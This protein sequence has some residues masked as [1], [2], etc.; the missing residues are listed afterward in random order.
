[1]RI[2]ISVLLFLFLS[3]IST[4]AA[5]DPMAMQRRVWSCLANSKGADDP[6]Y[7]RCVKQNC[8]AEKAA[9]KQNKKS[10]NKQ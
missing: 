7:E 1:M 3:S 5:E 6:A 10:K 4:S 8:E 9:T 2:A